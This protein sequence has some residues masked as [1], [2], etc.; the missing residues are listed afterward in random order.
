MA[1]RDNRV[2]DF[3]TAVGGNRMMDKLSIKERMLRHAAREGVMPATWYA[4][5]LEAA[6]EAGQPAPDMGLFAF[7]RRD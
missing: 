5:A 4:A 1:E 7:K 6:S 3:L 2:R